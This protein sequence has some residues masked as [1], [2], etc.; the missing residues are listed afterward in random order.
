MNTRPVRGARPGNLKEV[1]FTEEDENMD[2]NQVVNPTDDIVDVH[3]ESEDPNAIPIITQNAKDFDLNHFKQYTKRIEYCNRDIVKVHDKKFHAKDHGSKDKGLIYIAFNAGMFEA[4]KKNMMKVLKDAFGVIIVRQPKVE[5]YGAAEESINLDIKVKLN[6]QD[7]EMKIKVYN[8]V[9]SMDVQALGIPLK[10]TFAHLFNLTCAEYFVTHILPKIVEILSRSIDIKKLNE[11]HRKLAI[12]GKNASKK[13]KVN[14]S[15]VSC[16]KD[17]KSGDAIK[18]T[19]C[20]K[21]THK[22]CTFKTMSNA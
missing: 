1:S 14:K 22:Q 16:D 19:K 17:V 11:F 4:I 6:G 13:E 3:E 20:K 8:T 21:P 2:T 12:D 5:Y 15:C 18:C 10:T 7:Q 9:C